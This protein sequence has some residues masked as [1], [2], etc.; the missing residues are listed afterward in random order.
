MLWTPQDLLFG[1]WDVSLHV[2][3][4]TL[5][6]SFLENKVLQL[7][8]IAVIFDSSSNFT[9]AIQKHFVIRT[10]LLVVP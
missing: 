8:A 1:I 2:V 6:D 4:S 3:Q 10:M 7:M 9:E 5:C